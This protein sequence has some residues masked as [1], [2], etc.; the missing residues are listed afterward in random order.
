MGIKYED[1]L[2]MYRKLT[3]PRV[4]PSRYRLF[5]FSDEPDTGLYD[6]SLNWDET[7]NS[8][9]TILCGVPTWSVTAW[10]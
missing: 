9:E 5:A 1:V 4:K 8:P 6:V 3:A 10:A 7:D 2:G